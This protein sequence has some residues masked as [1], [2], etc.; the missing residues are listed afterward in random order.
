MLTVVKGTADVD[1]DK[2]ADPGGPSGPHQCRL[3]RFAVL[4]VTHLV[5]DAASDSAEQNVLTQTHVGVGEREPA[6]TRYAYRLARIQMR[7]T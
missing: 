4:T 2:R 1:R 5:H 6:S 3:L 7:I